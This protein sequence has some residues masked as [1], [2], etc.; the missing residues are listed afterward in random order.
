MIATC[1][2]DRYRPSL[3]TGVV[4]TQAGFPL[5]VLGANLGGANRAV[6]RPLRRAAR[7]AAP[8]PLGNLLMRGAAQERFVVETVKE[9]GC[10]RYELNP[11]TRRSACVFTKSWATEKEW[12]ANGRGCH[13]SAFT[14]AAP[15]ASSGTL[16]SSVSVSLL[17]VGDFT[18]QQKVGAAARSKSAAPSCQTFAQPEPCHLRRR[19]TRCF[20]PSVPDRFQNVEP[21]NR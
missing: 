19:L 18:M 5:L 7:P 8:V 6:P 16:P 15:A 9:P 10:L 14:P 1:D 3:A 11:P 12:L 13:K 2:S 20:L 17:T 4:P 21:E